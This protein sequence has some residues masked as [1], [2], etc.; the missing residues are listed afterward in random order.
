MKASKPQSINSFEL[1]NQILI[2]FW[3]VS[4]F[5]LNLSYSLPN[6]KLTENIIQLVFIGD[7]ASDLAEVLQAPPDI[8]CHKVRRDFIV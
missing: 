4:G 8:Q 1:D 2:R 5:S 7:L 6:T 3:S